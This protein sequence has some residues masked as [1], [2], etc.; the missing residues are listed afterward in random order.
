M[1]KTF[2]KKEIT[3]EV[4]E[5]FLNGKDEQERIVNLEYSYK[6]DFINVYYR[7]ENDEKCVSRQPFYPFL[8]AKRVACESL[9]DGDKNKVKLLLKKYKI[10]VKPLDV[11]NTKG[12]VVE[13]ILDGY[14]YMFY[15]L[16]PMSYSK[17]L[18]F[19][20]ECGLPVNNDKKSKSLKTTNIADDKRC[21]LSVTPQEQY[22]I[23]TGK[24]FFK[25]YDDYD[26]LLRMIFDL[27]STGLDTKK[28]RIEQFGIRF[29]RKVKYKGEYINFE[30][31]FTT[32][33]ET[34][35]E[36][37]ASELRNIITFLK[38]IY[39]FR[40]DVIT[41]HNG[42]NFDW[43]LIIGACERLGKP[44]DE[45]SRKYFNDNP[46]KKDERETIL[47]LGGE[48]E[49]FYRTIVPKTIIT[50]SLHAVRRAQATDSN[51]KEANLKYATKYLELKK[52][53]RVYVPGD[54]ISTV[55]ND[56]SE[57]YAFNDE[58]GD[59]YLFDINSEK[60]FEFDG[61]TKRNIIKVFNNVENGYI[62]V[63]GK[64]IVERY[65]LDDLWEC[66]KVELSLNQSAFNI[67]KYLPLP[68]QKC[69]T[70]GTAGQWK[71]LMLAW[72][73]ENDLAIPYAEN[74]GGFTGGLSRLLSVGYTGPDEN[75]KYDNNEENKYGLVKLDYNSLYPSI[76]LTW[77]IEDKRDLSGATLKFLNYFLTTREFYKK[78]KKEANK[79]IEK[80]ENEINSGKILSNDEKLEY[81]QA[82]K[83]YALNDNLQALRKV[84][85]NSFFGSY[86][87]NIGSVYP[88][89]SVDCAERTTCSGRQSLRLMIGHFSTIGNKNG[90]SDD[91]NYKP[92]V[93][94]SFT[95]DTPL[96]IKYK[97]S[98]LVD[99]VPICELI[100]EN[101]IK[102]DELG[103]EYDYSTKPYYVL[104]R[105][106]WIDPSYI[107]RHKTDKD[108][109]EIKDGDMLVEVTEDHSLF[110]SNNNKI[111]PSEIT[112][113][114]KLEYYNEKIEMPNTRYIASQ[115]P[116]IKETAIALAKG[117]IDRVPIKVI[118]YSK[119]YKESFYRIFM[120]NYD[121]NVKF[122]KTCL[123][124]LLFIRNNLK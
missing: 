75:Q 25:G 114:T 5:K 32:E 79:I 104:C 99:I 53:N 37:N 34:E 45:L 78:K 96:F 13:D 58:N 17:F 18:N 69:C 120:E 60:K 119:P 36:K 76:I 98:G 122:S 42:E 93:G 113:S 107:Y 92:I 50:D 20:K 123:A 63:N 97:D 44:L 118:N 49:T 116:Y 112:E 4:I 70:M 108:I 7:N 61:N 38:I 73:Y 71:A 121:E 3:N 57:H 21:Y 102:I 52:Q 91:Y 31:V 46:I 65:L 33:G 29:N 41:A 109:Y 105:S 82:L 103:R 66:D 90:L 68:F 59:W 86:G 124:G 74:T 110:D 10:W 16:E 56:L 28:D 35:E 95:G 27:E 101:Q 81:E 80:Y 54:K 40:P 85:C 87:S 100:D 117:E 89:K 77:G 111:K 1:S 94:D 8:W 22:L 106:G 83:E 55:W 39:T 62:L 15:S 30:R 11:T 84:F 48:I 23:S 19:F 26:Q 6:D 43:Y 64:Y 24:R 67:C 9:C 47:K 115:A 12:E 14:T 2:I 51:F 72:S 88:W